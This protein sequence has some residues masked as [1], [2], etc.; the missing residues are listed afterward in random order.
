MSGAFN[1][2]RIPG[3]CLPRFQGNYI[4]SDDALCLKSQQ[5]LL[6]LSKYLWVVGS[7]LNRSPFLM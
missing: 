6:L 3:N 7:K 2:I 4:N 5:I 1:Q